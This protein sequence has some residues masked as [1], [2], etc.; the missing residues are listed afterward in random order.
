MTGLN[1][2][3]LRRIIRVALWHIDLASEAAEDLVLMTAIA[4]S[5]LR[6]LQQ[7]EGPARG[8]WQVEP[9]T[10]CD[11]WR[12]YLEFRPVLADRVKGLSIGWGSASS[13]PDAI[14]ED[15]EGN[16]YYGAAICRV[17]YRR[18]REQL[19]PAGD[20]S[21]MGRYW[22]RYYNTDLGKGT[23]E[24]FVDRVTVALKGV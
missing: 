13:P 17:I 8:L 11:V 22:K 20:V 10:H 15:L 6:H 21:A 16:L 9:E 3:H 24:E 14:F 5:G 2:K 4:E 12:N 1:P 19:P 23:V 18:V 7:L